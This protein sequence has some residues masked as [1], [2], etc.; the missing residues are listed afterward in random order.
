MES[1]SRFVFTVRFEDGFLSFPPEGYIIIPY[2]K[3][4]SYGEVNMT[5]LMIRW[6]CAMIVSTVPAFAD[7]G[8]VIASFAAPAENPTDLTWANGYLYCYC[9]T[10][11]YSVYKISGANGVV[12]GSYSFPFVNADC[13]GL[14][15]DG[16]FFW[17]AN[18]QTDRI[19]RFKLDG[20]VLSSFQV[21]WDVGEGLGW[22]NIH[23]WG[24]EHP[25]G[26]LTYKINEMRA[27][28]VLIHTISSYYKPYDIAY[29]G[30]YYWVAEYDTYNVT[31]RIAA[32][33]PDGTA[34]ISLTAPASN[35][36]GMAYDGNY[37][38]ASTLADGGRFWKIES[39]GVGVEPASLGRVKAAYR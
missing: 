29:D 30:Q 35:V 1:I 33:M 10:A 21:S 25:R 36:R 22:G 19:Y 16:Y 11:P 23:L 3:C 32:L 17:A 13:A 6:V 9:K 12:V 14:A 2:A 37:I 26:S 38:W 39:R 8:S 7:I 18:R 31:D 27:D 4:R 20:S 24:S 5:S 15:Y 28:G 34:G